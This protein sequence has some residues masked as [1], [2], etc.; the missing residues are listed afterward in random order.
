MARF[1][2]AL[3]PEGDL[4]GVDAFFFSCCLQVSREAAWS[5]RA[6]PPNTEDLDMLRTN[7]P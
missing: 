7:G 2:E 6:L 3:G 1:S 4:K 5:P